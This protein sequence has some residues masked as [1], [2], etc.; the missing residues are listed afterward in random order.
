MPTTPAVPKVSLQ[1]SGS[2]PVSSAA[3]DMSPG[4]MKWRETTNESRRRAGSTVISS[5]LNSTTTHQNPSRVNDRA[6]AVA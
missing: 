3:S 2:S 1:T 6:D 4:R 5:C